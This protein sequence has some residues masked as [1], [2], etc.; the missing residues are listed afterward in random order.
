MAIRFFGAADRQGKTETGV[1]RSEYPAWY[2]TQRIEDL[3]ERINRARRE[4]ERGVSTPNIAELRAQVERDE[5]ILSTILESKPVLS[6]KDKDKLAKIYK[7]LGDQISDSM[8][9]YTDMMKG[10]ANAHEEYRRNSKP[11][12]NADGMVQ[13]LRECGVNIEPGQKM[14]TRNQA[15][16]AWKIIGGAL[17]E[18]TNVEGLRKDTKTGTIKLDVPL[19]EMI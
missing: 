2:H 5:Q 13:V 9:T 10:L 15:T 19:E 12:I 6:D 16:R 1:I 17:G 8:F 18:Q 11:C 4:L 14:V 7:E 3:E